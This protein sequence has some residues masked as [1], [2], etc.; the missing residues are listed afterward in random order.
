MRTAVLLLLA[1]LALAEEPWRIGSDSVVYQAAKPEVLTRPI[2]FEPASGL[3]ATFI[4]R[5]LRGAI[6]D[7]WRK[8]RP[9]AGTR[10]DPLVHQLTRA[11][12]SEEDRQ[13]FGIAGRPGNWD[14]FA[15][16]WDGLIRIPTGGADLAT[17]S[18]DGS[19]L[20]LDRDRDGL[21]GPS[22]W[23][24]N[25][26]GKSVSAARS[27]L[28]SAVPPGAWTI[29]LQYD[30][31]DGGN[32][33]SLLWRT[34]GGAWTPVP[35]EAFPST[36]VLTVLGPVTFRAPISGEGELRLGEGASLA[37][38]SAVAQLVISGRVTL[39]ADLVLRQ[40]MVYA[41]SVLALAG[42]RLDCI[43]ITGGGTVELDGGTLAI[44]GSGQ[45]AVRGP[46][47]LETRGE[48]VL[49]SV[50]PGVEIVLTG[51]GSVHTPGRTLVRRNLG[52]P[53][54]TIIEL[55]AVPA[56][57]GLLVVDLD[58]PLADAGVMAWR[59]DRHGRWFQRL[60]EPRLRDGRQR[61][62]I[63]LS[64]AAD[65]SPV[66]H[67]AAWN[68]LTASESRRAG[69]LLYSDRPMAGTVLAD[70][71][72]LPPRSVSPAPALR[73]LALPRAEARTGERVELAVRPEP[74][75]A[76]PLD[77][78]CFDLAL[79]V[80]APDGTV[81]SYAG[82]ADQPFRRLDR[83][84]RERLL[85]DGPPRFGV[86]FRARQAGV[87]R[88]RLTARWA[89]GASAAVDLPP[90]VA[91]GVAWDD[92]ARV[93]ARDPRFLSAQDRF[94][95]PIGQNLNSTYDVRSQDR[96]KTRL[97]LERGS[98]AREAFLSRLIAAGGTATET[99]LSPWNLGLEWTDAWAGYHGAGRPNLG[100]AWAL[101]RYL[102]LAER[103]GVRVVLSIFNH[104]QGRDG[105]K[106][107]EDFPHHPWRH[108]N[109]GW[110]SQPSQL[111]TDPRALLGQR[112][113][114]R[115]LAARWGDS[116]AVLAWKLWAEVDLTHASRDEKADWHVK[117]AELFDRHDPWRHPVT[118]HWCGTWTNAYP[119]IA[120]QPG[121]DLLTIDAYHDGRQILADLLAQST[122]EAK[123]TA[124]G[125]ARYGK[126]VLVTEYGGSASACPEPQLAAELAT[127]GWAG[128]VH[129]HA[130]APMMWWFEWIDQGSRYSQFGALR[131]FIA[132]EDLRDP[133]ARTIALEAGR[134][135]CR[136]WQRPGRMLG[137]VLDPAWAAQGTVAEEVAG[138]ALG[139]GEV[140]AGSMSL[141]WWDADLGTLRASLDLVHPGGE[142]RL[143]A[144]GFRRHL[145]FKLWRKVD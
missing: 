145:A 22:E 55:D 42:H 36:P 78:D 11:F 81:T 31:A 134:L 38:A 47:R 125:L 142:L 105:S 79:A 69:L 12:G 20:W 98:F 76:R 141:A 15:V 4:G 84:D 68:Q 46:G 132:D 6:E 34:S 14:N 77:P 116:P 60:A 65:L 91:S 129:G 102:D 110:L 10:R 56:G 126:P 86:R 71:R 100:N 118:T 94:V 32:S 7:D 62:E 50:D 130:G 25:N 109:G 136:A 48:L 90:L 9:V 3:E 63:D 58:G 73:L 135:W 123:R 33:C 75:P 108:A 57:A 119:E 112:D 27:Q 64:E 121:I 87:H 54:S 95:W 82:F 21:V 127:A 74:Y 97:T 8:T 52:A 114:F 16:Q 67:D 41:D 139:L 138:V 37:T 85:A 53:L 83:G 35:A 44:T 26:W 28:H 115:Y 137:Y 117:A 18:E 45:M 143:N 80:T 66:G 107:E 96:L 93:D 92:I 51:P 43:A 144:P 17:N 131:R 120:Q 49:D 111:F 23:G 89:G 40:P 70:A 61:L 103:H 128:L 88:L 5:S 133:T 140:A 39:A 30:A 99:W 59:A 1:I 24:S 124:Y 113:L 2:V 101:D 106:P 13:R 29:R 19:R 72:W 122:R 104:G